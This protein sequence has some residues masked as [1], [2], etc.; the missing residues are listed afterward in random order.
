MSLLEQEYLCTDRACLFERLRS[1]LTKAEDAQPYAEIALELQ[2]T[3]AA[4]KAAVHRLRARYRDLLRLEIAK[5]VV[6]PGEV[7][8][9]LRH[10]FATF[11]P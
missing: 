5:T 4:V 2:L 9:E 7:E 6:S 3:E 1:C 11:A 8:E 10:H